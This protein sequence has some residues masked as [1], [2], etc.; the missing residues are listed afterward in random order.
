MSL[1]MA[2]IF[3]WFKLNKDVKLQ[4]FSDMEKICRFEPDFTM[5]TED[6]ESRIKKE[7]L[8][9]G[10]SACGICRA[11]MMGD[12]EAGWFRS[13]IESG[14]HGEMLYMMDSLEKRLD[15]S[16]LDS[17]NPCSL[18]IVAMSYYSS[19]NEKL[20]HDSEY[21]VS[22]YA[23][24]RNYHKVMDKKL[25]EFS[26]VFEELTGHKIRTFA[27]TAPVAEKYRARQAGMGW[28]GKNSCLIIP[29]IGSWVV[30]GVCLTDAKLVADNPFVED[31]CGQCTLCI[32]ACPTGALIG[33]GKLDAR[34]CISY[35]TVEHKGQFDQKTPQWKDWIWGCDICQEVCPHNRNVKEFYN[36]DFN[37]L[38][39][40]RNL[41]NGQY[42]TESFEK[43]FEGTSLKRGGKEKLP[44]NIDHVKNNLSG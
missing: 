27:D 8:S 2:V 9:L 21:Q 3:I 12:A 11:D 34:K 19:E 29:G 32:D 7:A 26:R 42:S 16:L 14:Y 31:L 1:F 17:L 40:I 30:L 15:P 23:M 24:G 38:P 25:R 36:K 6:I 10:F 28:T 37:I 5:K 44:R 4:S 39:V 13:W 18:I 33:P 35:L 41:I 20:L 22:R 43:D